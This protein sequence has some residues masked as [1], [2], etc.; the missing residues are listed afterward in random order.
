M[1]DNSKR[2]GSA[3]EPAPQQSSTLSFATPTELVD[4]PSKGKFYPVDHPLHGEETIE[5]KFMTARDEDILTS[6][7]LL[8]KGVAIDRFI[9]NVIV[10]ESIKVDSLLSGDKAAIMISSRINGYGSEY[11]TRMTCPSCEKPSETTFDLLEIGQ[12]HG[13][14][15][16]ASVVT[17][18]ENG[19]FIVTAPMSKVDVEFRLMS[20]RDENMLIN[21]MK[22]ASEKSN[23]ESTGFTDQLRSIVVSV[24]GDSSRLVI[25][26]FIEALTAF[27]SRFIRQAYSLMVPGPDM[28]QN[29]SCPACGFEKE[30]EIPM[31][32]DFFWFKQ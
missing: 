21:K 5:I 26:A 11:K 30:V 19:T 1:R 16:D 29:F 3:A 20:S 25:N 14:D 28:K 13:D 10:D 15:Y 8:K 22:K 32:V 2:V 18:T 4:L 23:A 9:Q 12:Y 7:S 17:P 27:D 24:N 31:S 6:P